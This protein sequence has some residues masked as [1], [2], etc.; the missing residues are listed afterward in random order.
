MAA[1]SFDSEQFLSWFEDAGGWYDKRLIGLSPFMGM[2]YGAV[3][4]DDIPVDSALFHVPD[5]LVLSS[6]T[7]E[8]Q[9]RLLPS[10][11][12]SLA[13]GWCQLILT[14]MWETIRG[15]DSPWHGYLV[16]LP[17]DFE[18]P[19]LWS[20]EERT[21]LIGTDIEDRIGKEDA[22]ADHRKYLGP[23]IT[24][25][26]ELFP[27]GSSHTTLSAFHLQGSRILSRSFTVPLSR[28]TRRH[29]AESDIS[30][31][32]EEIQV[33]VMIPFADM[34][35]AAFERDN[36][37]LYADEESQNDHPEGFTMKST[38]SIRKSTQIYNTYDSP[39]NSEL[40]RKYGH[41]DVLPLPSDLLKLL[42]PSDVGD[43]P[44]GN[45]GDEV[46]IDGN[47]VVEA[48]AVA[49]L[50]RADEI[51]RQSIPKRVD[52]WLEEGQDDIFALALSRELDTSLIAFVRLLSYDHEWLRAEKKGK[53]PSTEV[54]NFVL[55][56]IDAV[57]RDR[58]ARYDHDVEVDLAL[59]KEAW[60]IVHPG[61]VIEAENFPVGATSIAA[62]RL[63]QC[64]AAVVR[65]GE[66]R[67]LKAI[68]HSI[69]IGNGNGKKRKAE[70]DD[71]Q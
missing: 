67:I 15:A 54:D 55:T 43:W 48:V 60:P 66:K 6:Y 41:V 9:S 31:D 52:W 70:A 64:Y 53:L 12:D 42:D 18:T 38:K 7:S 59:V 71:E 1:R 58:L 57:I 26:P 19:M 22:E 11:W 28:F 68:A 45:A 3:A 51:W 39:P 8:L 5:K 13:H 32:D 65:L 27:A 33:A 61:D 25:H 46:L 17:S 49:L 24:A 30:D 10:E 20:E 36:V 69:S 23:V 16:N 35:N 14:M 47:C 4:L 37:H 50:D 21:E 34:L 63:R 62:N 29:D 44:Y 56:V 2:G 40:L